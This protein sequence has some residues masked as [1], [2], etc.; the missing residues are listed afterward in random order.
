MM[1]MYLV[2][3]LCFFGVFCDDVF[4]REQDRSDW[5]DPTDMLNFDLS[6]GK[7]KNTQVK[8][9]TV[10]SIARYYYSDTYMKICTEVKC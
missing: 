7:L 4:H 2:I 8:A 10:D 6:S 9:V 5:V 1:W 3:G